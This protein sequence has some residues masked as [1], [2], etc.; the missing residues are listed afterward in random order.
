[1]PNFT[2]L[3]S[4]AGLS[5]VLKM[6]PR[7]SEALLRL[8]DDIMC[9]VGELSRGEREAIAAYVSQLNATPYC[10]FNHSL[11]AEV[12]SGPLEETN[13][14]LLPLLTYVRSLH[15]KNREEIA[16]A[17]EAAMQA[18]W[19]TNALYEVVEV[20]GIFD[21]I[22]TIV[23]SAGINTPDGV[24]QPVPTVDDLRRSYASMADGLKSGR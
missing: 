14:R 1:M 2:G 17:H 19:S 20:C 18:G 12:F 22:N 21:F 9:A 13:K 3:Q 24:M 7:N 4:D 11:F 23:L 5:D 8:L 10:V 16:S 15:E 6:F